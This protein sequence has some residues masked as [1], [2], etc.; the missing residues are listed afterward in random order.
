MFF[1]DLLDDVIIFII[2]LLLNVFEPCLSYSKTWFLYD[3]IWIL[4]LLFDDSCCDVAG[5]NVIASHRRSILLVFY[6]FSLEFRFEG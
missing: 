4:F 6:E 2:F 5:N 1:L 3:Q